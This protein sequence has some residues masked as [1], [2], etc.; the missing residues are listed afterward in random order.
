VTEKQQKALYFPAWR[1]AAQN[2]GWHKKDA[3]V[4]VNFFSS[5]PEINALY[6]RIWDIAVERANQDWRNPNADEFRHACHIVAFGQ[7]KSSSQITNTEL[8][9]ILALFKLLA[10]PD[11]L[12]ATLAWNNPNEE[13]RK[14]MLWWIT[15][16]CVESYVVEVC[17]Q[18]FRTD[19]YESL[20]FDDLRKLHMTLKNRSNATREPAE[21]PF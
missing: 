14:R 5:A 11:D 13:R 17:R 1:A 10:D 12:S 3:A 19:D 2:H 7:D 18:K 15:R 4:R 21:Q 8:D 20:S 9:R 16:N 6:Q